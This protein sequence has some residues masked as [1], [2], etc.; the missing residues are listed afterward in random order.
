MHTFKP[1]TCPHCNE[2]IPRRPLKDWQCPFCDADVGIGRSYQWCI[3]L[4]TF[5]TMS[6]LAVTT[7]ESTSGGAWLLGIFVTAIPCWFMFLNV[8]PPW[9]K[10]GNN[11]PRLTLV[12]SWLTAAFWV[13]LIEFM[14]FGTVYVLFGGSRLELLEHLT[15]LS[16]HMALIS[17]NFLI[18]PARSFFDACGVILG[19]SVFFGTLMFTCYQIV[20]RAFRRARPAQF[21]LSRSNPTEDDD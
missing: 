18:T 4:L 14:G 7:H 10:P 3:G 17:S 8:V 11:Q 16:L 19:N 5:L 21:S 12:S 13:F 1:L 15:M 6:L 20:H 2:R 9:L